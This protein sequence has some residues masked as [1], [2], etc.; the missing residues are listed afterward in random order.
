MEHVRFQRDEGMHSLASKLICSTNNG[1]LGDGRMHD[2]GRL[3]LSSG[4]TVTGDIDDVVDTTLNPDITILIPCR[5]I[6]GV[7]EARIWL[8]MILL[9][10][11]FFLAPSRLTCMYVSKY[12]L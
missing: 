2:K 4:Q 11:D 3:N 12:R 10:S 7:E 9:H 8:R 1:G 5:T 6:T